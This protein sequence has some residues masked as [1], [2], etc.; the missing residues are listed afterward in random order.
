MSRSFKAKASKATEIIN[1]DTVTEGSSIIFN[2]VLFRVFD[3]QIPIVL[4]HLVE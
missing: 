2:G 3:H 4:V 1:I